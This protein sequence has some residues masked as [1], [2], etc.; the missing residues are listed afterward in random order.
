MYIPSPPLLSAANLILPIIAITCFLL[1]KPFSTPTMLNSHRLISFVLIV[2]IVT[3][4]DTAIATW[5]I[6]YLIPSQGQSCFLETWWQQLWINKDSKAIKS[7]QDRHKCCGFNSS[8][9]RAWPFPDKE[10]GADVCFKTHRYTNGCIDSWRRDMRILSSVN[11]IVP[12]F[13]FL[14]L[15]SLFF[16]QQKH[17][18]TLIS[19]YCF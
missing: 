7:I 9:D 19:S 5:S 8:K 17:L 15:V 14:A 18:F 11:L 4:L 2:M 12:A 16:D 1:F 13:I 3:I 10:N 6:S